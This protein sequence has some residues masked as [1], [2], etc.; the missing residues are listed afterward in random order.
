MVFFNKFT[1]DTFFIQK[2]FTYLGIEMLRES[3]GAGE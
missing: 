1:S 2:Y 3:S